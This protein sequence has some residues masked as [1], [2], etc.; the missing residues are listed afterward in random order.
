MTGV[1]T[2]VGASAV[3]PVVSLVGSGGEAKETVVSIPMAAR[4]CAE[5]RDAVRVHSDHV[6]RAVG[7]G[8]RVHSVHPPV[9]PPPHQTRLP[10]WML[11]IVHERA[12]T[13]SD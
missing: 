4:R 8:V 7:R 12:V 9:L 13:W 11:C 5:A 3:F 2:E 6:N 10:V 1:R